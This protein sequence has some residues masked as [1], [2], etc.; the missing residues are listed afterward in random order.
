VEE[1]SARAW[2]EA[3]VDVRD[4]CRGWDG[5]SSRPV[6]VHF[7]P[8]HHAT[9]LS[10]PA[11]DVLAAGLRAAIDAALRRATGVS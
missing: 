8:G 6:D 5:L 2:R 11:V 7:V 3:G 1:E 4:R 10:P 9:L